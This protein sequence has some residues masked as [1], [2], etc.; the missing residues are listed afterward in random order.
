VV[1]TTRKAFGS[2]RRGDFSPIPVP[3]ES[4]LSSKRRSESY[5]KKEQAHFVLGFLGTTLRDKDHYAL[6]VLDAALSGQGGRLFYQLRDKES[7]AYALAFM[8]SSNLDP[9]FIG[10]YMGTHPDKLDTAIEGVLR[11]LRKVKEEGLTEDEVERAKRYLVGNFEIGLQTNGSQ[12]NT[13]SLDELYG[14][15]YDYYQKYPGEIQKVTKE[16]VHQVAQKYFNLE[17]YAIAIIRPPA[18]K[19]E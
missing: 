14:M 11:E 8:A 5:Q 17:A 2:L 15:G 12:A 10:V 6:E 9:G 4:P 16:D 3:L 7:L 19:K 13:M 18:E 1:D